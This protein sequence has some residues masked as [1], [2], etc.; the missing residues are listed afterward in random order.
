MISQTKRKP[1]SAGRRIVSRKERHGGSDWVLLL[2]VSRR[3][4]KEMVASGC[5]ADEKGGDNLPGVSCRRATTAIRQQ[6]R[7]TPTHR[8]RKEKPE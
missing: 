3:S 5:N 6:R 4:G 8:K 2:L 1:I 7:M